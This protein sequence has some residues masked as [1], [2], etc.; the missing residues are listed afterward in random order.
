MIRVIVLREGVRTTR[1]L[2][3]RRCGAGLGEG[4]VGAVRA[5]GWVVGVYAQF[6]RVLRALRAS[7]RESEGARRQS[8]NDGRREDE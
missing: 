7:E 2:L 5:E 6:S 4:S 3:R 8:M 1:P